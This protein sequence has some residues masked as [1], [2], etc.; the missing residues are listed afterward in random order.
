MLVYCSYIPHPVSPDTNGNLMGR[1]GLDNLLLVPVRR[2]L[3]PAQFAVVGVFRLGRL[4]GRVLFAAPRQIHSFLSEGRRDGCIRTPPPSAESSRARARLLSRFRRSCS[5]RLDEGGSRFARF[6]LFQVGRWKALQVSL[7]FLHTFGSHLQ[8]GNLRIAWKP[9]QQQ[10]LRHRRGA[11]AR[12]PARRRAVGPYALLN[13]RPALPVQRHRPEG[14]G[15]GAVLDERRAASRPAGVSRWPSDAHRALVG[16]S[17]RRV[18]ASREFRAG[19]TVSRGV[20]RSW[21]SPPSSVRMPGPPHLPKVTA[22]SRGLLAYE[23]G[24]LRNRAG[25]AA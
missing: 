1:H 9:P 25:F 23:R 8:D 5:A 18:R 10:G 2:R 14:G 6:Q 21:M 16:R 4:N 13:Q 20:M 17:C 7:Q 24:R 12:A 3:A 11:A 15:A 19:Q 22:S